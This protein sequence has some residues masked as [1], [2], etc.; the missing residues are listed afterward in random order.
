MKSPFNVKVD[1]YEQVRQFEIKID[2]S[3]IKNY[4]T[5][6][7]KMRENVREGGKQS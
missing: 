5:Y 1:K 3:N 7:V 4:E 6:N 2:T